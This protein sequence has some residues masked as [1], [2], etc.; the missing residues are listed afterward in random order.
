MSREWDKK[1]MKALAVNM[2]RG[3]A[4]AFQKLAQENDTTVGAMLRQYVQKTLEQ[5]DSSP[6]QG[7]VPH[8]VSYK[9]TDLLKHE[10][11][12]H[13]PKH[14]TPDGILN[15]ILDSYFAFVKKVRK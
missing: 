11:A 15:E 10:A 3:E 2:K 5:A 14:L 12:F 6:E 9:N 7:G 1:N 13:N 4:E 8:C